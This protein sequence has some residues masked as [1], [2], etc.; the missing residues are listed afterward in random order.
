MRNLRQQLDS[1]KVGTVKEW[2]EAHPGR[3]FRLFLPKGT[4]V[5]F[6]FWNDNK[7]EVVFRNM[8][9]KKPFVFLDKTSGLNGCPMKLVI[10]FDELEE[11]FTKAEEVAHAAIAAYLANPNKKKPSEPHKMFEYLARSDERILKE[12]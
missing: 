1:L 3:E 9:E 2:L 5:S 10:G 12:K 11:E 4:T 6:N 7:A 8:Y